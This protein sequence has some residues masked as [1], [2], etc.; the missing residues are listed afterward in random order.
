MKADLVAEVPGRL[1]V[2][3]RRVSILRKPGGFLTADRRGTHGQALSTERET[4]S[5]FMTTSRSFQPGA[6]GSSVVG[7]F[8]EEYMLWVVAHQKSHGPL[9]L[10]RV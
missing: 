3:R 1:V 7:S 10:H 8:F 5:V 4:I 6:L 2:R 9:V